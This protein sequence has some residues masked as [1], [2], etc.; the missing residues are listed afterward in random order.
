MELLLNKINVRS[1]GILD[2]S[3]EVR[4][5]GQVT[6]AVYREFGDG[7]GGYVPINAMYIGNGLISPIGGWI[8][9]SRGRIDGK[10]I[11]KDTDIGKLNKAWKGKDLGRLPFN[12]YKSLQDKETFHDISRNEKD[13]LYDLLDRALNEPTKCNAIISEMLKQLN[14][15]QSIL[16]I[17]KRIIENGYMNRVKSEISGVAATMMPT[18]ETSSTRNLISSQLVFYN[19]GYYGDL[20]TMNNVL[21]TLIHELIHTSSNDHLVKHTEMGVLAKIAADNM[22]LSTPDLPIREQFEPGEIGDKLFEGARTKIFND[23]IKG[24]CGIAPK[25]K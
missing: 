1:D 12:I 16:Q 25:L 5:N 19:H 7:F 17:F 14:N 3:V 6:L 9:N 2:Q 20:K 4:Y 15:S 22:G 8:K 23:L 11:R 24:N 13:F 18:F 10:T 21:V